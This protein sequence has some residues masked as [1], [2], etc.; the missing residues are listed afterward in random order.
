MPIDDTE[1]DFHY[2]FTNNLS[3]EESKAVYDRYAVPVSGR[4]LFQGGFA[5]VTPNAATTYDFA[6]DK[7]AP[8]LFI[9]GGNDHI[10]P[11]AVQHENFEKN[12]KH[13]RAI[14]AY[15]LFAGRSHYTCG[16][17]GWEAVADFALDWALAP[18]AGNLDNG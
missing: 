1:K 12:V 14:T 5:N 10:L 2:A 11:P 3:V 9:A 4:M 16:E 6:N 7:R 17:K 13:S 18:V 15:K 8:L